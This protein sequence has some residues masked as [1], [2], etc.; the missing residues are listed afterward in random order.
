MTD[1]FAQ[2][3][4]RYRGDAGMLRPRVPFRFEPVTMP[5]AAAGPAGEAAA[6]SRWPPAEAHPVGPRRP[7]ARPAEPVAHGESRRGPSA[8]GPADARSAISPVPPA[9]AGAEAGA[10]PGG[11]VTRPGHAAQQEGHRAAAGRAAAPAERRAAAPAEHVVRQEVAQAGPA[12]AAASPA[13]LRPEPGPAPGARVTAWAAAP[14]PA[15]ERAVPPERRRPRPAAGP[16][17]PATGPVTGPVPP[18]GA[19]ADAGHPWR[20][21]ATALPP[22]PPGSVA[23]ELAVAAPATAR[24]RPSGDHRAQGHAA[25]EVPGPGRESITVQ[26]TIGRV[27]VRAAPPAA[28]ERPASA[29]P[30]GPSLADYLRRRSRP[31]GASS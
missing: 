27:E 8:Q 14:E 6:E 17:E 9:G 26:V 4:A 18:A 15:P 31:A 10:E 1:F 21:P 7:P 3:A 11:P 13:V 23:H 24:R 30:A 20:H 2:L 12:A 29:A 25:G 5:L 28:A 22:A 19:G 16:D